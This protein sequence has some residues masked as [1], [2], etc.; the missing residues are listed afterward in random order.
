MNIN[1]KGVLKPDDISEVGIT[2]GLA[3]WW[4]LDGNVKDYSLNNNDSSSSS[5]TFTNGID[6]LARESGSATIPSDS[7]FNVKG[8]MTV[9]FWFKPEADGARRVVMQTA[10][11]GSFCIN[12]E[13]AGDLRF[14][15]GND[16]SYDSLD[17]SRLTNGQ[18]YYCVV[19]RDGS[20]TRWYLN[21]QLDTNGTTSYSG[22][23]REDDLIIG[24]GYTGNNIVGT[25]DEVRIY[26]RALSEKEILINYKM[27]NTNSKERIIKA[28]DGT[29]FVK[30]QLSEVN[31]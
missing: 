11:A 16:S 18:W 7:A 3:G 10:Y 15:N 29:Q 8:D 5:M 30:G 24:T 17:S 6:G 22:G 13:T 21:G 4:K 14:Y 25:L 12:H 9:S 28:D 20:N 31:I 19:V 2:S 1:S 27:T 23:T 26:N